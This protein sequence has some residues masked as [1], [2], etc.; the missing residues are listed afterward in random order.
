MKKAIRLCQGGHDQIFAKDGTVITV[1]VIEADRV[2]SSVSVTATVTARCASVWDIRES[3]NNR[4]GE[5]AARFP[6]AVT[7]G[8]AGRR[9][10]SRPGHQPIYSAEEIGSMWA[11]RSAAWIFRRHRWVGVAGPDPR[12]NSTAPVLSYLSSPGCVLRQA[13]AVVTATR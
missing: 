2:P 11:G 1:T 3:V 10:Y 9:S 6:A 7:C 4:M 13:D 8:A 12:S 5:F